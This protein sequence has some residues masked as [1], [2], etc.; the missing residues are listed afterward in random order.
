MK[1]PDLYLAQILECL[2]KIQSVEEVWSF[3]EKDVPE[4]AAKVQ[5]IMAARR[6]ASPGDVAWET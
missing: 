1:T 6:T 3:V 5:V 4:L 2:D